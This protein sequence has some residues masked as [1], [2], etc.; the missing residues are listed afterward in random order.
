MKSPNDCAHEG[1]GC[2]AEGASRYCSTACETAGAK[3][4]G[5]CGCKHDGCD[6]KKKDAGS[7]DGNQGEGNREADKRYREGAT[8]F[9][10]SGRVSEAARDAAAEVGL[11]ELDREGKRQREKL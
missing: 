10:K 3:A 2:R 1:C 5:G 7:I 9:A 4:S 11:E 6:A 8:E